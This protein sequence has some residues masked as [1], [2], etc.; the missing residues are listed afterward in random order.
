MF[1]FT[2]QILWTEKIDQLT[3]QCHDTTLVEQTQHYAS[4]LQNSE[5]D[6][7]KK[8]SLWSIFFVLVGVTDVQVLNDLTR[9]RESKQTDN[10]LILWIRLL[11]ICVDLQGYTW[12]AVQR[13]YPVYRETSHCPLP[14]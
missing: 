3:V 6:G 1:N 14:H 9:Q 13:T 5:N 2:Y 4:S 11:Y 12:P 10:I 8:F 7:F